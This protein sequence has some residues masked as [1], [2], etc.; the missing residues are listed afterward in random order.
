MV[1]RTTWLFGLS[2]CSVVSKAKPHEAYGFGGLTGYKL[3]ALCKLVY[4]L[5]CFTCLLSAFFTL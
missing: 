2:V 1:G 4:K 5:T 3:Y